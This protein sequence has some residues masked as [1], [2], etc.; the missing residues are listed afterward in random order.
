MAQFLDKVADAI[1]TAAKGIGDKAKEVSEVTA[2]KGKYRSQQT[3][4]HNAYLAIGKAY[5]EAHKNDTE[6]AFL[7][8]IKKIREATDEMERIQQDIDIIK[9]NA[10]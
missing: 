9:G 8:E 3:I 2:L 10:Q 5:Y 4:C 1:D 7:E 6:D